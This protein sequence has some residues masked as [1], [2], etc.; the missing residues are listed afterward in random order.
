MRR[1]TYQPHYRGNGVPESH[2][3]RAS[4]MEF[5][6]TGNN[7]LV[8]FQFDPSPPHTVISH[9]IDRGTT[10]QQKALDPRKVRSRENLTLD[11]QFSQM[12]T[13]F[14]GIPNVSAYSPGN[15]FGTPA[16]MDSNS[17]YLSHPVDLSLDFDTPSG[18]VT[19][20]NIHSTTN[21]QPLFTESPLQQNFPVSF[22]GTAQDQGS[23]SLSADKQILSEKASRMRL[24]ESLQ[25]RPGK[26]M[27]K[28][29]TLPSLLSTSQSQDNVIA[30]SPNQLQQ[31]IV[32]R[33]S[34]PE[35]DGQ[36]PTAGM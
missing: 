18:D 10:P 7:T 25:A 5:G 19:P 27:R 16:A 3:R 1:R 31:S 9:Q 30:T 15:I 35:P 21:H 33:N 13:N 28:S 2:M 4:M 24:P 8:D 17:Q 6:S 20:M 11:T 29:V 32:R 12:A 22:S 34:I 26:Q 23:G 36:F 14:E